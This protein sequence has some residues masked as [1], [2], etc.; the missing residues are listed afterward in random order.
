M[1]EV[2]EAKEGT[3]FLNFGG[4]QPGGTTIKFNWVHG[5][6]AWFDDHS[7]VFYFGDVELTL[8]EF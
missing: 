7:E 4:G 2:G 1:I 6:L 3:H 8:F 5:E